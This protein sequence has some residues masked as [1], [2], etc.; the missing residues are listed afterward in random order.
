MD[1]STDGM[2]AKA[3]QLELDEMIPKKT[4]VKFPYL[5]LRLLLLGA[6]IQSLILDTTYL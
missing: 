2:W 1:S 3:D 6:R 4:V 5:A